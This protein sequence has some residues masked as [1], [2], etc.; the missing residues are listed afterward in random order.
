M[1]TTE[2]TARDLWLDSNQGINRYDRAFGYIGTDEETEDEDGDDVEYCGWFFDWPGKSASICTAE[3]RQAVIDSL[4][5]NE[6][7]RDLPRIPHELAIE[8]LT[9]YLAKKFPSLD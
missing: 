3:Q 4:E 9:A 1:T 7:A 6:T 2:L 5:T 8:K